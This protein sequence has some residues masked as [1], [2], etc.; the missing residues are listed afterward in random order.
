MGR[1][2]RMYRDGKG[3]EKDLDKAIEWMRKATKDGNKWII[4]EFFNTL[5]IQNK[6]EYDEEAVSMLIPL[7]EK[8]DV[9]ALERLSWAYF[10]G[11]GVDKDLDVAIKFMREATIQSPRLNEELQKMLNLVSTGTI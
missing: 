2:G 7:S 10:Y 11:R 3:V 5:W 6:V 1:L 4:I 8:K 9:D